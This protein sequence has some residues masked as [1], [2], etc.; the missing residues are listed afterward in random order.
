MSV[1]TMQETAPYVLGTVAVTNPIWLNFLQPGYQVVV[2]IL[3]LAVLIL[4]IRNKWLEIKI[5]QKTLKE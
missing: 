2:G 1:H 5:K 4:T 3:G